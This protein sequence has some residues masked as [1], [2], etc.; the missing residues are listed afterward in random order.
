MV[1]ENSLYSRHRN[2]PTFVCCVQLVENI[3]NGLWGGATHA[4]V[5]LVAAYYT[6]WSCNTEVSFASDL[7]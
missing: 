1:A 4:V 7:L 2:K 5:A 3:K 6:G